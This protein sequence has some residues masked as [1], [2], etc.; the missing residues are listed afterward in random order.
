M[1]YFTNVNCE[2]YLNG[3][4]DMDTT[5]KTAPV[6]SIIDIT[7][8]HGQHQHADIYWMAIN[9][10][11]KNLSNTPDDVPDDYDADRLYAV[12]N[13]SKDTVMIQQFAFKN[14]FRKAFEFFQND[15]APSGR[16]LGPKKPPRNVIMHKTI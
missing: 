11:S 9:K 7:G 4:P 8:I 2:G 5:L 14:I 15:V 13:N 10:R 6:Q 12:I 3:L 16:P 1:K